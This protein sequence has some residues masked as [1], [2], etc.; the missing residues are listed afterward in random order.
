[1]SHLLNGTMKSPKI[2]DLIYVHIILTTFSCISRISSRKS[3]IG[4]S[5]FVDLTSFMLEK[6]TMGFCFYT[7]QKMVFSIPFYWLGI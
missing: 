6:V 3:S 2:F 1:M 5:L 4:V 7:K